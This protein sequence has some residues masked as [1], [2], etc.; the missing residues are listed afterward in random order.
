MKDLRTFVEEKEQHHNPAAQRQVQYS[1][2]RDLKQ[3]PHYNSRRTSTRLGS[4]YAQEWHH[5]AATET[6]GTLV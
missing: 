3:G 1:L 5:L 2:G 4:T 6:T